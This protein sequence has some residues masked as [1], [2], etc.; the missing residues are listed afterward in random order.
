MLALFDRDRDIVASFIT[1]IE[2]T[3]AVWRRLHR[4]LLTVSERTEADLLFADLS[5]NWISIN[6]LQ[7]I[8]AAALLL[9]TRYPLRAADAI[10]LASAMVALR[11]T[12]QTPP[13]LPFVTLDTDLASAAHEEGFPVLP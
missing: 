12:Q 6:D 2:V 13:S 9:L 11:S 5:R 7:R 8:T 10:Q 1:P 4:H 3:S